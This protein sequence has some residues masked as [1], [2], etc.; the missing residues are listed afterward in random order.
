MTIKSYLLI[1]CALVLL[2]CSSDSDNKE[3]SK[4]E[5]LQGRWKVTLASIDG[6]VYPV[7]TPGFGQIRAIFD[8]SNYTYIFPALD[9]NNNPTANNDSNEGPWR[10]NS[11]ETTITLDRSSDSQPDFEWEILQ[12]SL[13]TL[14][15]RYT[16]PK[17]GS[18]T[19]TS[20][21]EITY[22]LTAD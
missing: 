10:F 3:L 1:S 17:A 22:T 19:E 16:A 18:T 21:Y 4:T 14:K 15:T 5:L 12:L 9:A 20:V 13:G 6:T 11:T 7:T 2:S 8:G